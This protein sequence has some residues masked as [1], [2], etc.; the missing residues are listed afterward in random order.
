MLL[1]ST[2]FSRIPTSV[3][4]LDE[5]G[6]PEN[7]KKLLELTPNVQRFKRSSSSSSVQ[8]YNSQKS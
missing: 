5:F 8:I 1:F 3:R 6:V 7:G 2:F 4:F